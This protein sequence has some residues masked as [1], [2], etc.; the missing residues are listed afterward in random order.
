MKKPDPN[1]LPLFGAPEHTCSYILTPLA[2]GTVKEL[3]RCPLCGGKVN[4]YRYSCSC[5]KHGWTVMCWG[6]YT[7]RDRPMTKY[8]TLESALHE[9]S[10]K[11]EGE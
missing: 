4:V 9:W 6:C 11:R 8:Q 5:G 7:K 10:I 1:T 2:D 3:K